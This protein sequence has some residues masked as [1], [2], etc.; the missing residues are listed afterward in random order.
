MFSNITVLSQPS[1]ENQDWSFRFTDLRFEIHDAEMELK[2][3][4]DSFDKFVNSMNALEALLDNIEDNNGRLDKTVFDFVNQNNELAMALGIVMPYS[5]AT[6]EEQQQAGEDVKQAA[7]GNKEEKGFFARA[8]EAI[9]NFFTAIKNALVRVWNAITGN[10]ENTE[11]KAKEVADGAKNANPAANETFGK[12][13][14]SAIAS[15]GKVRFL[16]IGEMAKIKDACVAIGNKCASVPA[17]PSKFIEWK[18]NSNGVYRALDVGNLLKAAGYETVVEKQNGIKQVSHKFNR[19]N[20]PDRAALKSCWTNPNNRIALQQMSVEMGKACDKIKATIDNL[21]AASETITKD[22]NAIEA[23]AVSM[24][25]GSWTDKPHVKAKVAG[26]LSRLRGVNQQKLD[27]QAAAT[28]ANIDKENRERKDKAIG[29]KRELVQAAMAFE[30]ELADYCKEILDVVKTLRADFE[31][32]ID[33]L[34]K[35]QK[36]ISGIK[37]ARDS[38]AKAKAEAEA[39]ELDE[40]GEKKSDDSIQANARRNI[41]RA[42]KRAGEQGYQ[43]A[44]NRFNE[45]NDIG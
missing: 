25:K 18:G 31:A 12:E 43:D 26:W 42:Q 44:V 9:K 24:A 20:N 41:K 5:F 7:E 22:P 21:T 6:E 34:Y 32:T 33:H 37:D 38:K 27:E 17:D 3:E 1:A 30:K 35:I 13:T 16:T 45:E 23:M 2:S 8:W 4:L 40:F 36:K 14:E 11:Q 10:N 39:N 15:N 19:T 29:A 28:N